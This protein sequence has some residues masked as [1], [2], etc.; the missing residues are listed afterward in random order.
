MPPLIFT[1][2]V[3]ATAPSNSAIIA[4]P[5]HNTG[6][7]AHSRAAEPVALAAPSVEATEAAIAVAITVVA[8]GAISGADPAAKTATADTATPEGVVLGAAAAAHTDAATAPEAAPEPAQRVST[9][10]KV[11]DVTSGEGAPVSQSAGA[12]APQAAEPAALCASE[13]ALELCGSGLLYSHQ[14]VTFCNHDF[15]CLLETP[16][17]HSQT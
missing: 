17:G 9:A 14:V 11:P 8:T 6:V 7:P 4:P 16:L 5:S 3:T 12:E 2:A 15:L 13:H 1:G 10:E